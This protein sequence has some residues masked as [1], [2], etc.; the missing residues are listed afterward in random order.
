MTKVPSEAEKQDIL[1]LRALEQRLDK[2]LE[3]GLKI[4]RG[5]TK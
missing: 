5:E 4:V 3:K 2:L 1:E